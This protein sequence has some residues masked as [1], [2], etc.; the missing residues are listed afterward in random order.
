VRED[1]RAHQLTPNDPRLPPRIPEQLWEHPEVRAALGR[2]SPGGN[3]DIGGLLSLINRR[4]GTSQSKIGAAVG[5]EQ[6]YISKVMSGQRVIVSIDV[7]ER[8]ADGLGM[9]DAAR[10]LLGLAPRH[11][12]WQGSIDVTATTATLEPARR[13]AESPRVGALLL[14]DLVPAT[15]RNAQE[16]ADVRRREFIGAA[17]AAI[18]LIQQDAGYFANRQSRRP[19]GDGE[20]DAVREMV[21]TF[22]HMDQRYGGGHARNLV[23]QYL[24]SNVADY[25]RGTFAEDAARRGMFSAAGEL[26]YLAGWMAFD[27]AEHSIAQQ[28][29][30][31]AVGLA[32]EAGDAPLE[33][34]VLRAMAHQAIDLG[35]YRR[36]LD[37]AAASVEGRRYQL[38]RPRER[39]LIGVVHAHALAVTGQKPAAARALTKAEGELSDATDNDDS[40]RSRVSF[41]GEASLAHETARTLKDGGDI[42][43]AIREFNRSV[44]TRKAA[45]F[46]RTHAVTLGYLGSAYAD[47]GNIDEACATWSRALDAMDGINSGRTRQ[48]VTD[49]RSA[50]SG[51]RHRGTVVAQELDGRARAYLGNDL[52]ATP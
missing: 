20:V 27:N 16:D 46:A 41:F 51:Y 18:G 37:L 22:S 48:V 5:L 2:R 30:N 40:E 21:S 44:D 9:P 45:A 29:Y 23:V 28:Y 33:G 19:V 7:L 35:S 25:L 34:H 47:A 43:G 11:S 17:I 4:T 24:V 32:T 1:E 42:L 39:A 31:L 10:I 8:I 3:R 26:S 52:V 50:L 14:P 38:A 49:M 36:G 13:P 6:G 15:P 12:A